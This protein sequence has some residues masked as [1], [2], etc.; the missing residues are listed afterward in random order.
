MLYEV[1]DL[2]YD[3]AYEVLIIEEGQTILKAMTKFFRMVIIIMNK[4]QFINE[5]EGTKCMRYCG[6]EIFDILAKCF[7]GCLRCME[8]MIN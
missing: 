6:F 1:G 2:I 8:A 7:G 5:N 4:A 3:W